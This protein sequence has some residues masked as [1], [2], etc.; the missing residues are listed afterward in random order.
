LV[1]HHVRID[2]AARRNNVKIFAQSKAEKRIGAGAA[3]QT[4]PA[5][6]SDAVPETLYAT[7]SQALVALL[8]TAG[9]TLAMP[10]ALGSVKYLSHFYLAVSSI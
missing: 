3:P 2:V 5:A 9:A 1:L 7:I 10:V 4:T 6:R 8:I